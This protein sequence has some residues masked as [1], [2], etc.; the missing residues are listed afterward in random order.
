MNNYTFDPNGMQIM[1]RCLHS[2]LQQ[3]SGTGERKEGRARAAEGDS[4][5]E[6]K[7]RRDTVGYLVSQAHVIL[8]Q[9]YNDSAYAS[10][11]VFTVLLSFI[12]FS[13]II[14]STLESCSVQTR[15]RIRSNKLTVDA[16]KLLLQAN[17]WVTMNTC[18]NIDVGSKAIS[19]PRFPQSAERF[20]S[21]KAQV[22]AL[23]RCL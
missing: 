17:D 16:K 13:K 2:G 20:R 11:S 6:I 21:N 9:L 3:L 8:N 5:K 4:A 23:A 15:P 10:K 19:S 14:P 7:L 18:D 22:C 1:A 12:L